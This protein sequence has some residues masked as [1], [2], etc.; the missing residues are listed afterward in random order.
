[1]S[2][3]QAATLWWH[4]FTP[5]EERSVCRV[6]HR[7]FNELWYI[8]AFEMHTLDLAW[9]FMA[10]LAIVRSWSLPVNTRWCFSSE[11]TPCFIFS[12]RFSLVIIFLIS[13][14]MFKPCFEGGILNF[15]HCLFSGVSYQS[16]WNFGLPWIH[17]DWQFSVFHMRIKG[18]ESFISKMNEI[19]C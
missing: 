4:G 5:S 3:L 8:S 9:H 19:S 16:V 17:W 11:N 7:Y 15:F 12:A 1:M 18:A 13:F 10:A 14:M 2:S 6:I